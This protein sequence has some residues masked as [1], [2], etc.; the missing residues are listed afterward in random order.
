MNIFKRLFK[1]LQIKVNAIINNQEDLTD[2]IEQK[3]EH[4][5]ED[6]SKNLEYLRK[7]KALAISAKND[8]DEYIFK[9]KEY[10]NKAIDILK[11]M[12]LNEIDSSEGNRLA[13]EALIKKEELLAKIKATKAEQDRL[14]YKVEILKGTVGVIK[15]NILDW[16]KELNTLIT[17]IKI[18]N[19]EQ[20]IKNQMSNQDAISIDNRL[21]FLKEKTAQYQYPKEQSNDIP[22]KDINFDDDIDFT[23]D[24]T[25]SKV[26]E[27]LKKLK[28]QLNI[29]NSN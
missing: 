25:M 16:E 3:L 7:V 11:K 18:N 9:A 4:M 15:S 2:V 23:L 29:K 12:Q 10:E 24:D 1:I 8:N 22:D 26:N 21:A 6:L 27:E 5:R 19:A 13:K 14:D 17:E 20:N 28:E